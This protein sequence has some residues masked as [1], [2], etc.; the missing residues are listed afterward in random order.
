MSVIEYYYHGGV[1][2]SERIR[3]DTDLY[4][5]ASAV[6]DTLAKQLMEQLPPEQLDL[7]DAY[8]NEKAV[9]AGEMQCE[10]FRQ[11]VIL[12]VRLWKEINSD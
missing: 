8:C 3:P 7:F 4:R 11:G 9:M 1:S 2:L 12:G 5:N 6:A 10:C